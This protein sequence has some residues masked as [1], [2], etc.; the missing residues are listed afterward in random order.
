VEKDRLICVAEVT[1]VHGVK[2][3]VKLKSFTSTPGDV[4]RYTPLFDE[5]GVKEFFITPRSTNG[6]MLIV[7]IKGVSDRNAA[8]KLRGLKLFTPRSKLPKP[9]KGVFYFADLK[10]LK[11]VQNGKDFGKVTDVMNFGAGDIIEIKTPDGREYLLPFKA[12]FAVDPDVEQGTITV[13]I[14]SDY[15][16]SEK[17]AKKPNPKT[18]KKN[19]SEKK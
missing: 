5:K 18:P 10:G 12:P 4:A 3:E 8:E 15:P 6:E 16:F 7:G 1:S 14:P 2:G 17:K 19:K 13:D 11:A 9:K